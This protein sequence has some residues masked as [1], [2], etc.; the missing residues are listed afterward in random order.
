[1][2]KQIL[3]SVK[4][5]YDTNA[6]NWNTALIPEGAKVA[7]KVTYKD[8]TTGI[9]EIPV[10]QDILAKSVTPEMYFYVSQFA[11]GKLLPYNVYSYSIPQ[12]K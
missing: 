6:D 5:K 9:I 3:N 2:N 7:V 1:M 10:T 8:K 12:Y 11:I 4:F